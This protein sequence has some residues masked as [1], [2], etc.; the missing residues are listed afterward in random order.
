MM[1]YMMD[2]FRTVCKSLLNGGMPCWSQ[3]QRK[4]ISQSD[5]WYGINLLNVMG[6]LFSKV[7]QRRLQWVTKN[8]Y[9]IPNAGLIVEETRRPSKM[10]MT[11][12]L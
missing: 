6:K 2:L 4:E 9:L 1:D 7:I 10:T 3:F 5:N 8:S 11:E 12:L